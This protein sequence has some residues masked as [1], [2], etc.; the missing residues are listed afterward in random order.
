MLH[1]ICDVVYDE[2]MCESIRTCKCS[3]TIWLINYILDASKNRLN[4]KINPVI[5]TVSMILLGLEFKSDNLIKLKAIEYIPNIFKLDI[6]I[7]S[8]VAEQYK[9]LGNSRKI[10]NLNQHIACSQSPFK[11]K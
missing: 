7:T 8:Q 6:R 3:S 2:N 5:D 4:N 10:S 11:K 9:K 1:H